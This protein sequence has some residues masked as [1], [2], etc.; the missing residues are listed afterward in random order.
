MR[1]VHRATI[2]APL[3]VAVALARDVSAWPDLLSD[4]RWCRIHEQTPNRLV[5][6]MGAWIRGWPARWTAV[7]ELHLSPRCIVFRHI[8]GLTRG[9]LVEWRFVPNGGG[10]DVEIVHEL[11]LPWPWI[12][13]LVSDRIVGPWFIDHIARRTLKA[14]QA[15]AEAAGRRTSGG[16]AG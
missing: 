4:Y 12:G 10:V 3:E 13:R 7:Q 16:A 9:M 11:V 1:T 14:V 8:G 2:A 5:F 15:R 6:S